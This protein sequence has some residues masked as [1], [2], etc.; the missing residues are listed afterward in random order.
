MSILFKR[1]IEVIAGNRKFTFPELYIGFKVNFDTDSVP[2][3]ATIDIYNLNDDSIANFY[4]G[5]PIIINAG[6]GNDIGTIHEGVISN[7]ERLPE[8]VDAKIEITSYNVTS[9]YLNTTVNKSYG[10]GTTASFIIADLAS[11]LGIR[12]NILSVRNE[13]TYE[14]G[15][16]AS[17][18]FQDVL[19]QLVDD[20]ESDLIIKNSSINIIP[21]WDDYSAGYLVSAE[22]GL[23]KVDPIHEATSPYKYK[24]KTILNHG[25]E[26]YGFIDL[27]SMTVSGRMLV[28]EG[29]HDSSD[30]TTEFKVVPI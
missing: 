2:D 24:I 5:Q 3:E 29:T 26:P 30:F 15:Y 4:K 23:L 12:L 16:Y 19:N 1:K 18:K 8:G 6:Y 25:I 7:L 10:P 14:R 22:T 17:G 13:V 21:G 9:E 20:T 28:G 27:Q 11:S